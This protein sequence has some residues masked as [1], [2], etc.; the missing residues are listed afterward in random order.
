MSKITRREF[1][2]VAT[3]AAAV[4]IAGMP[5]VALASDA[6]SAADKVKEFLGGASASEGG[7]TLEMPEIA[8][9]GNTVPLQVTVDGEAS[10]DRYAESVMVLADGNPRPEVA[11]LHFSPLSGSM[12]ASTRMRLAKTQNVIAVAKMNDGTFLKTETLVKVTIGGCGG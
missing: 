8:E 3:G 7:I 6:P 1:V 9:N 4:A 10:A 5:D 11:T 12:E 2:I